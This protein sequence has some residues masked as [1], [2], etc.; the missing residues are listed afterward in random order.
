M[1]LVNGIITHADITVDA[2][3][4]MMGIT[5]DLENGG[6]VGF[7]GGR[8]LHNTA[9]GYSKTGNNCA[10]YFISTVMKLAR[11]KKFSELEGKPIRAI[12]E[13]DGLIG[14]KIIGIQDFLTEDRF[15][16]AEVFDE[17]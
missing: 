13:K 1:K 16:P 3:F 14:D 12:F 8:V 9:H 11:A 5:L 4:M 10:G 15:I 6:G 17:E 2:P 7:G